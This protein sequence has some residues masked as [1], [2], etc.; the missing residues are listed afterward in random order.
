M[1]AHRHASDAHDEAG[2]VHLIVQDMCAQS[3]LG[4]AP[5]SEELGALHRSLACVR[6]LLSRTVYATS[7]FPAPDRRAPV[8][9]SVGDIPTPLAALEVLLAEAE[10][11]LDYRPSFRL[12]M[13]NAHTAIHQSKAPPCTHEPGESIDDDL[14]FA[15]L[16]GE[17]DPSAFNPQVVA[18]AR[19]MAQSPEVVHG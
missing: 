1:T 12:A 11:T 7:L 19:G 9:A 3:L 18:I 2:R 10:L 14:S 4:V 17:P 5:T 15:D 8:A 16:F 6:Y 13:S